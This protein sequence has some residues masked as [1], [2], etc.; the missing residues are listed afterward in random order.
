[1]PIHPDLL[2]ILACPHDRGPLVDVD[3]EFLYNPRLH[4]A[5]PIRDEVP[6]LLVDEARDV[7]DAEHEQILQR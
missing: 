3:G 6:I 1:M 4:R 7:D 5:Y 2:A